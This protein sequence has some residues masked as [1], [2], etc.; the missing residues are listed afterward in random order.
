MRQR[1]EH[2]LR[3]WAMCATV[4]VVV[5]A[6]LPTEV[7]KKFAS[8]FDA[9]TAFNYVFKTLFVGAMLFFVVGFY[10]KMLFECGFGRDIANRGAWL[11]LLI[12]AP[13]IGVII[14]YWVT[15]SS[16]YKSRNV[17]RSTS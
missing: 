9:P 13:L 1:Q 14:Y 8:T 10:L 7:L 15:R 12:L 16:S 6:S 11:T 3:L 4:I 2:L 5:L 17:P